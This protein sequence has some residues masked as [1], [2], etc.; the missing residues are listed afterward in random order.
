M[1]VIDEYTVSYM[2]VCEVVLTHLIPTGTGH[3]YPP[4]PRNFSHRIW[5]NPVTRSGWG[6]G[7]VPPC[8]PRGYATGFR[9]ILLT[10]I[11]YSR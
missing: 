4:P 7:H 9:D 3:P 2:I 8:D 11:D 10:K 1:S 6:W 5:T